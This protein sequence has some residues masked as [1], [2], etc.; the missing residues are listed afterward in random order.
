M[1]L[2]QAAGLSRLRVAESAIHVAPAEAPV[3]RS[4]PYFSV[5]QGVLDTAGFLWVERSPR[6]LHR[7]SRRLQWSLRN[8]PSA[9]TRNEA[10][11]LNPH[12][13]RQSEEAPSG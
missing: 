1:G 2:Y 12:R 5:R 9:G 13:R 8:G 6:P 11:D 4:C 10:A 3:S 7:R